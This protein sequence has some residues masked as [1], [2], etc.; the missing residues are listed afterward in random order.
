MSTN[1]ACAAGEGV[2][3]PRI[4]IC[5][6]GVA[7]LALA[8]RLT[9]LGYRPVVFE[10]RDEAA[11]FREGVFLTLAPNG[12][13]GLRAIGCYEAVVANGIDTTGIEILNAKGKRLALADQSDHARVFG[14]PSV[15]IRRGLLAEI[16]L[17]R[18]RAVGVDVRFNAGV[19]DVAASA[20]GVHL[21]LS[22]G[23]SHDADVLVA[24]DG[25]RSQVREAVFPEYPRPH[26]T[27]LI[28][29]GGV[30]D[31]EVPDTGGLMRM[32][33][34][35]NAFFGYLKPAGR[36]V[37]WFNSYPAEE[38][39]IDRI[40][41]PAA[42]ARAIR[43]LHANDPSPNPQILERVAAIDRSYP[44]Y[45]MPALPCWYRGRVVLMGDAAHAVGPHAGQGAS[46]AI[47]D[48]LVLAA[49]LEAEQDHERAFRRYEKLRRDRIALVVRMTARNGSQKRTSGR[50]GV[51]IR[52]LI[53]PFV[54]PLGIRTARR[55]FQFRA[56]LA[57]LVQPS[58]S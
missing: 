56:D 39:E 30:T 12:T 1:E 49:C 54:I 48:A 44:I 43:A 36:P 15:T 6:A 10:A 47:E 55:F 41:G 11:A 9:H 32:T 18:A 25:L 27:G 57:P 31:A 2:R 33:F 34:G 8:I 51:L 42:H 50:L 38:R 17:A 19:I 40:P 28:G 23:G 46:M 5:G 16:L 21:Q 13:N 3:R 26:F 45:D 22:S 4:A 58:N 14:A 53:L 29:T 20:D 37:H 7:G 35:D 24:A 52:D